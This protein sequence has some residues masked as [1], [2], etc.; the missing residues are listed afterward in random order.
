M[1]E[2]PD[3]EAAAIRLLQEKAAELKRLPKKQDFEAALVSRI[4]FSLGPWPRAIEKAGLKPVSQ[5]Y[6]N[7]KARQRAK[8]KQCNKKKGAQGA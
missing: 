4:K 5:T 2:K 1:K 7:R 3:K 6:L 8:R